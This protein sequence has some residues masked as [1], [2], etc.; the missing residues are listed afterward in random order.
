MWP[1]Y[2]AFE[3]HAPYYHLRAMQRYNIFSRYLTKGT[4]LEEKKKLLGTKVCF[5][6][7][8]NIC[9]KYFSL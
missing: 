3:G 9:L 4:I 1:W 6:F 2:P 8:Y 7:L 5:D